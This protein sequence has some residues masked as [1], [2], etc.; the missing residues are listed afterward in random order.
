[1]RKSHGPKSYEGEDITNRDHI[2][3][4]WPIHRYHREI[5]AGQKGNENHTHMNSLPELGSI[6]ITE[7]LGFWL[8][9]NLNNVKS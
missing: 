7:L 9:K 2:L 1:M 3:L 8:L 4:D 6:S 5:R